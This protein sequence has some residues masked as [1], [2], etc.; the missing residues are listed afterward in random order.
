MDLA[1]YPEY[2]DS[3]VPWIGGIPSHWDCLPHRALFQ[4][5]KDQGHINEPLLSVTISR[6]VITQ[7]DLLENSSKKDSSNLDKSKYKLVVPG[8]IAYNKMR[9]WQGSVGSS[10]YRGIVSP[11]YIVIRLRESYNPDYF[12]F[13]F[14]T[15]AFATEAERW[16]YG[17]TSDQWSLRPDHF[18][19][20]YSCLPP[21]PEQEKVVAFLRHA[22][23][24]VRQF[25]RSKQ[26]IISLLKEQKQNIVNRFITRGVNPNTE[27]KPSGVNWLEDIPVHW[28]IR[29]FKYIFKEVDARSTTGEEEHLSMSQKHGGLVSS[30]AIE[31]RRL[32]SENYI[33][34]KLCQEGDIVLN[35]LKAHL[36]VFALA[37]IN[38]VVS[39]DYT[40]LRP[41]V[42][43]NAKYYEYL[44]RSE[45]IRYVLRIKCK[46]IVEG[47]WR[48]YTDDFYDIKAPM[49]PISEQNT[50]VEAITKRSEEIET[51]I[52]RTYQEID[53]IK[54]YRTR[55]IFDVVT[56]KLD[57]RNINREQIETTKDLDEFED[58]E[59]EA[60]DD[61]LVEE[62]ANDD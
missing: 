51:T 25:V 29:R 41:S 53:Y 17:I 28:E 49:P 16:S 23:S 31:E 32:M 12:H 39:P 57:V 3:G 7:A 22:D 10:R 30:N 8:D 48:L 61:E 2:K 14:R 11:A 9:A 21:K 26:K 54:E 45:A 38:G 50:I 55:L 56:G 62:A 34:G 35:R 33:G 42:N 1:P 44:L 40:V 20:I 52:S 46:G 36:G 43:I 60:L 13:L 19:M 18:K 6:G 37:P 47:F 59:E 4:E 5:I 24:R 58:V 15:P 27:V